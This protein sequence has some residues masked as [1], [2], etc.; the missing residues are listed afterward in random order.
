MPNYPPTEPFIMVP[1]SVAFD[2]TL[3]PYAVRLYAALEHRSG[4][5]RTCW[6]GYADLALLVGCTPRWIPELIKKLVEAG[7][8]IVEYRKGKTNRYTLLKRVNRQPRPTQEVQSPP[9]MKSSSYK[10]KQPTKTNY[11]GAYRPNLEPSFA[12]KFAKTLAF[13]QGKPVSWSK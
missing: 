1:V 9:P 13:T 4:Q 12:E 8:L 7:L 11:K 2:V 5:N 3:S 10:Q 6:P